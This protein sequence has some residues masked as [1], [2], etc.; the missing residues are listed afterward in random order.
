MAARENQGLQIALI[1]F[2]MLTLVTSVTAY[3]FFRNLEE[4]QARTTE[5]TKKA[6][7]ATKGMTDAINETSRLKRFLGAGDRDAVADIEKNYQADIDKWGKTFPE[8]KK[9]YRHLVE[10]LSTQVRDVTGRIL[11]AQADVKKLEAKI[12]EIEGTKAKEI[13]EYTDNVAKTGKDLADERTKFG[14]SRDE[15]KKKETTLA[16]QMDAKRKEIEG[17]VTKYTGQ[18]KDLG[19]AIKKLEKK[20]NDLAGVITTREDAEKM[21]DGKIT[22]V[23]Q[24]GRVV[25]LNLGSDDGLRRQTS[26]EVVGTDETNPARTNRKGSVEVIRIMD[27]HMAEARIVEDKMSNP[28]M[29]NDEIFSA[30]WQPGRVEHFGICGFIDLDGDGASDTKRIKELIELNGGVID[31]EVT[32]DGKKV[33]EMSVNTR[34]LIR[35]DRPTEKKGALEGYTAIVGEA[36]S[37]GVPEMSLA[38]F[39]DHI[40]YRKDASTVPLGK[41]ARSADFKLKYPEGGQRKAPGNTFDFKPRPPKAE[42]ADK[43]G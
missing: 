23:N 43:S 28:I 32:E 40:G 30:V 7:V 2:V 35:G 4:E 39:L 9:H 22:W 10:Y 24:R 8:A 5:A 25:W 16:A 12:A 11:D 18:I 13:K 14:Q 6:E 3:F 15:M 29:P 37:L 21:P 26:F 20:N 41:D 34:Y 42:K 38:E 27:R 19:D 1:I 31:A 17:E 33:G 36:K